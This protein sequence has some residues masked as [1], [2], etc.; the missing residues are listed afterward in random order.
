MS[1]FKFKL[2]GIY[3]IK[4]IHTEELYIGY[5]TN[6][7]NR[8]STHLT[9]LIQGNHHSPKLQQSYN[10]YGIE[11]FQFDILVSV[12]K[13]EFKEQTKLKGHQLEYQFRKRLLQLEK[14]Q[15]AFFSVNLAFNENNKYFS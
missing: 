12:S 15:M 14:S 3:R 1:Y 4:N 11:A 9:Q 13:T 5:S 6:I 10:K 2:A 7:I 8:W